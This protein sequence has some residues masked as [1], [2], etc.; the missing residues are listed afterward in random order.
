MNLCLI[1][2]AHVCMNV[3]LWVGVYVYERECFIIYFILKT[4]KNDM[5]PWCNN[6]KVMGKKFIKQE[7]KI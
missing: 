6:I 3:V 7:R 2:V 5:K 4:T 1:Y